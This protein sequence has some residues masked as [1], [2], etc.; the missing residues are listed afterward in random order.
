[1]GAAIEVNESTTRVGDE[2]RQTRYTD[3][4]ISD[5]IFDADGGVVTAGEWLIHEWPESRIS[6]YE[7]RVRTSRLLRRLPIPRRTV[8]RLSRVEGWDDEG[9]PVP[10]FLPWLDRRTSIARYALQLYGAMRE[11]QAGTTTITHC[12]VAPSA[13]A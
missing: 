13:D 7:R 2:V 10:G 11:P 4:V 9:Y 12:T 3:Q 6:D 8:A 1:M 5:W